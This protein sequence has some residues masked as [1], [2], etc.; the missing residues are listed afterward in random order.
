LAALREADRLK[1]EFMAVVSHELRTP[2]TAISG[3]ADILLRQ[4]SGA[5]NERQSRQVV[6]I[7]DAARR[8]L[9]LINDLLDVS[10]LE[11]GTLELR[12]TAVDT[13]AALDRAV[14]EVRVVAAGTSV[15]VEVEVPAVAIPPVYA[16]EERLQQILVNLLT[17]AVKFTPAN[18]TVFVTA[19]AEESPDGTCL[20]FIV[21]DTG[22]GLTSEQINRVWERFYQ[23]EAT[24]NRRFGGT[25]LGLSI[26]RRLV[27]LHGGTVEA[28]SSGT[29]QGSTFI[30]RIPAAGEAQ[31]TTRSV[32]IVESPRLVAPMPTRTMEHVIVPVDLDRSRPIVLVVEDDPDI[33]A[34]VTTYLEQDGYSVLH[35]SDGQQ[36]IRLAREERPF[37]ILLD[38]VL[39]RLDGWSVLNIL[40]REPLT[41]HIP[42]I[43]VSIVDNRQFGMVL[44]A[45][46]YLVKPV[47]HDQLQRVLRRFEHQR[48]GGNG[49]LVVDDD[50][51]VLDVLGTSLEHDGWRIR[52]AADGVAALEA[53]RHER[54]D[55]VLLDL[56]MPGLDG[57][58]VLER[59]RSDARTRDLPVVV[60][61]AKN[62]TPEERASL[63]KRAE[64]FILKEARTLTSLLDQVRDALAADHP[65]RP[66]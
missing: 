44:G 7:R 62:L 39:P 25:G 55:I 3:Y 9:S 54:P 16:D 14:G 43:V 56:M 22:I 19:T 66:S 12:L 30:V 26:V 2:L 46:D 49:V 65:A 61:T 33:A 57:F 53:I 37:A 50:P 64:R 40:K 48:T 6:G 35:A 45:S 24:S 29:G 5:L 58:E 10:K 38:V 32:A 63:A 28:R 11:A 31:A 27:E 47:N 52:T 17:N 36:A 59:L 8:L 42:V 21:R 1:D 20:A 15:H 23:A 4:M 51:A 13:R 41:A 18:G 60:L 34:V